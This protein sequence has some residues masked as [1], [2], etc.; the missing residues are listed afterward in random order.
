MICALPALTPAQDLQ[1]TPPHCKAYASS[2]KHMYVVFTANDPTN[3][4]GQWR[5]L[6]TREFSSQDGTLHMYVFHCPLRLA[7]IYVHTAHA[8]V[9]AQPMN[10]LHRKGGVRCAQATWLRCASLKA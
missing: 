10:L 1:G 3:A 6:P 5:R 8:H 2:T 7:Q 9:L 4:A